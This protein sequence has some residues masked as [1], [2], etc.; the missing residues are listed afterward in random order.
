MWVR[1]SPGQIEVDHQLKLRI[2]NAIHTAMV[3]LM[4]SQA[5]RQEGLIIGREAWSI[6]HHHRRDVVVICG[7]W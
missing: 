6:K 1:R 2:A 4:V 5:G 3:Y 7:A